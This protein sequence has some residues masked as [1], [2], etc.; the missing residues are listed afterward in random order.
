MEVRVNDTQPQAHGEQR[1][2]WLDALRAAAILSVMLYH[3]LQMSPG[4]RYGWSVARHGH[5]GVELFFVL[6]GWLIGGLYWR[7]RRDRGS[8]A[9]IRFWQRRWWRTLPPYLVALVVSWVVVFATRQE[10]FD[11]GYLVFFQ[12]YYPRMPFFLVSWSLCIEEHFYLLMPCLVALAFALG[13]RTHAL[14]ALLVLL[15][16]IFRWLVVDA[17]HASGDFGYYQTA[18]HLRLDGLVMG[19]WASAL[20]TSAAA[21]LARMQRVARW[22]LPVAAAAL[23]W[24][25][26]VA[27]SQARFVW[28]PSAAGVCFAALL[29]AGVG[30]RVTVASGRIAP[31]QLIAGAAYSLYLVHPLSI[32]L[33]KRAASELGREGAASYYAIAVALIAV[34]GAA[35]HLLVERTA[36]R[37]RERWSPKRSAQGQPPATV[38]GW[39]T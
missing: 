31:V 1:D 28:L 29:L 21:H 10:R 22:V 11:L 15:P 13:V 37:L 33:A 20:A 36:L 14:F 23:L 39:T 25:V 19:F 17:G 7:E 3:L 2:A 32:H 12:N 4:A 30:R 38:Q 9:L 24:A 35:F 8:V 5:L 18:T 34:S 26:E 16:P 6:S 27:P